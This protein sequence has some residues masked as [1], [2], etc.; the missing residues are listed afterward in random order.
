[1]HETRPRWAGLALGLLSALV[2]GAWQVATRH[3]T[4]TTLPA[5]ELVILRYGVP[6]LVLAPLLWRIGLKPA[7]LPA[8]RLALWTAGAGLPFGLLAMSGSR[9]APSA[10]MGVLMAG[11]SPLIAAGL[12]WALW[13]ERPGGARALGLALMAGGVALLGGSV[14]ARWQPAHALG[15][16]LFLSAATL[17]AV[18]TLTLRGSTLG[19]WQVAAL[20]NAWSALGVL[21]WVLLRGG[22]RLLAAP[23]ADIALQALWQGLIAGLLGLWAYGAAVARLGPAGAAAFGALVPAISALGGWWW[24]GDALG[25]LDLAAVL[26]AVTGVALASGALGR[27]G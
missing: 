15:D 8:W 11:A 5:D 6:A 14:L 12:A 7:G 13:R 17:W 20:V 25:P 22:S 26:A 27:R 1:M 21:A 4:T 2:G 9:L 16:L 10:H 3:S 18:F 23:P 24:L 19:P